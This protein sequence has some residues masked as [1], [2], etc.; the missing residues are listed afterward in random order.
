MKIYI[1]HQYY[2]YLTPSTITTFLREIEVP[3]KFLDRLLPT[4]N[5]RITSVEL[6]G[7][8]KVIILNN[9]RYH[10]LLNLMEVQMLHTSSNYSTIFSDGTD[11]RYCF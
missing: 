8:K 5:F 11:A 7:P 10:F 4:T 6:W 3:P 9:S 1:S 2:L